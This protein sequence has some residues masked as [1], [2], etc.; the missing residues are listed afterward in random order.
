MSWQQ[1]VLASFFAL[2]AVLGVAFIGRKRDVITPGSAVAMIFINAA[3][4]LM[5]VT[6]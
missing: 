6:A 2:N 3:L 1:W 4:I 5:V